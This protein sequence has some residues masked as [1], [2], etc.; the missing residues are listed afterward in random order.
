MGNKQYGMPRDPADLK[1]SSTSNDIIPNLLWCLS[2]LVSWEDRAVFVKRF[3][4]GADIASVVDEYS[5]SSLQ[6]DAQ[7]M[8]EAPGSLSFPQVN[9]ANEQPSGLASTGM[10]VA[11]QPAGSGASHV[12]KQPAPSGFDISKQ[13][14]DFRERNSI[15]AKFLFIR[16]TIQKMVQSQEY[17]YTLY[18]RWQSVNNFLKSRSSRDEDTS[19]L[20]RAQ[21]E[22]ERG[23]LDYFIDLGLKRFD[24]ARTTLRWLRWNFDLMVRRKLARERMSSLESQTGGV[25]EFRN[26][27]GSLAVREPASFLLHRQN[28][29]YAEK[30][31][32]DKEL[33]LCERECLSLGL[34][35]L[36]KNFSGAVEPEELPGLPVYL[37]NRLDVNHSYS[38]STEELQ[39][40]ISHLSDE[41]T[42]LNRLI[43]GKQ[44][45][46]QRMFSEKPHVRSQTEAEAL[47][48]DLV[49]AHKD[50]DRL[51]MLAESEKATLRDIY[52]YFHRSFEEHVFN[53]IDLDGNA[54]QSLRSLAQQTT[55]LRDP[56]EMV[57]TPPKSIS[58]VPARETAPL[59]AS[60]LQ[61]GPDLRPV[62]F[63]RLLPSSGEL[64]PNKV[65]MEW[66]D[67]SVAS[68]LQ[69]VPDLTPRGSMWETRHDLTP[70]AVSMDS[71]RRKSIPSVLDVERPIM[72]PLSSVALSEADIPGPTVPT[73]A[74][75]PIAANEEVPFVPPTPRFRSQQYQYQPSKQ[76]L[77]ARAEMYR[78]P[79]QPVSSSFA[80]APSQQQQAEPSPMAAIPPAPPINETLTDDFYNTIRRQPPSQVQGGPMMQSKAMPVRRELSPQ[81]Q[82][83]PML[84][85]SKA[86]PG[87][88]E[89]G[90]QKAE[91]RM[92]PPM[93]EFS[94][95]FQAV[96]ALAS[97][98]EELPFARYPTRENIGKVST[99]TIEPSFWHDTEQYRR[100]RKLVRESEFASQGELQPEMDWSREKSG[101]QPMMYGASTS[102]QPRQGGPF[103]EGWQ[104]GVNKMSYGS[105]ASAFNS[106]QLKDEIQRQVQQAVQPNI[107]STRGGYDRQDQSSYSVVDNYEGPRGQRPIYW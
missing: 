29:A 61:P 37:F 87:V 31:E 70:L 69:H 104:S 26:R 51:T 62:P 68:H 22:Q 67:R 30:D 86:M 73:Q 54:I 15:A 33:L 59:A 58:S 44:H 98:K 92:A 36:D 56:L 101:R 83:G 21:M 66:A 3:V 20:D 93:Q 95:S 76:A 49:E 35:Y 11:N 28:Q 2:E 99:V 25:E 50:L 24:I 4:E 38:L 72:R 7:N 81:M 91:K 64:P 78:E 53:K 106:P 13:S 19:L 84:I 103:S 55:V 79:V 100:D 90:F 32:L 71:K 60:L 94:R 41:I 80:A 10:N 27:F 42:E 107:E 63:A 6:S 96:P 57:R 48:I 89:R 77:P 85:P 105:G 40:G 18:H 5:R 34:I 47:E 14:D 23:R 8:R 43:Y 39:A 74:P 9:R 16:S 97:G 1:R 82:G 102:Y 17:A 75:V 65:V 45:V 88:E 46:I 12:P 52:L